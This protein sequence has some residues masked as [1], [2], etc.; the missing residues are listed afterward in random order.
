V[1]IIQLWLGLFGLSLLLPFGSC[2]SQDMAMCT[3]ADVA[4]AA[5]SCGEALTCEEGKRDCKNGAADGCETDV[6][7]DVNNCGGCGI[8]CPA[9]AGGDAA[10][11]DG[12]CAISACA[13]GKLDCNSSMADGC[14]TDGARDLNNCGTCGKTCAGGENG[15]AACQGGKCTL[16]CNAGYLDCDGNPDNGCETNGSA[17]INHC[18]NCGNVC[19]SSPS[20]NA[21]CAAGTCITTSCNA[22]QRTCKAGPIDGCE[23]NTS[24]DLSHCGACGK[25]CPTPANATPACVASNCAIGM[26]SGG[27]A[28]CDKALGNGCEIDLTSDTNH[29]GDCGKVCTYTNAAPKCTNRVCSMGACN[30]DYADCNKL[31][32]DGCEINIKT[33]AKNC[34]MCGKTCAAGEICAGGTCQ[35]SCRV[36]G[37]IRWCYN[38]AACGQACNDVCSALGLP[39]T[40]SDAAWLA[41]QDTVPECQAI[42]D[43]FGLGGTVSVA[44]YTYACLEDSGGSYALPAMP[45]GP[46]LC[47]NYF[48]CP[49]Q[50]RTNMDQLGIPCSGSSR[51]SICPC[52]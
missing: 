14:E 13:K 18:G 12:K 48:D 29:C 22:P 6:K 1:K 37:G 44:S 47:S 11:V 51:L 24:N 15:A 36:V 9:P 26:C 52:Q 27:F 42:N 19:P 35:N 49:R 3:V 17:D 45:R 2:S 4:I 39:F 32:S 31:D 43:A 38:P 28:D 46:L 34:G 23:V 41:A 40:I 30:P 21:A 25:K 33:D 5:I 50:H 10:C 16:V 7:G 8:V 20:L